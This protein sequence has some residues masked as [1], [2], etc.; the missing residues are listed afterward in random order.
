MTMH[1]IQ[2]KCGA[3]KGQVDSA[4]V[5]SR[6][7]CHCTDCRAFARFLGQD[8]VLDE[9][10]GTEIVQVAQYRLQWLQGEG[11]LAAVR[12]S[13]KGMVRWY[14]AC[15]AT[16]IGNTMATPQLPFIGLVHSCLDR[17]RMDEDFG[18]SL[19]ILN[20]DT[21]LG[22]PKPRQRGLLGVVARFLWIVLGS[23]LAGRERQS[24]LFDTSGL[25]RVDP[26]VLTAAELANLKS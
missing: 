17:G 1:P 5:H 4:G 26:W 21:A 20:T 23:R 9:R 13:D 24:P 12:L 25:P 7:I 6:L 2:C 18:A 16:P 11:Q 3:L 19:A 8:A 14:A 10:G 15:C 22:E